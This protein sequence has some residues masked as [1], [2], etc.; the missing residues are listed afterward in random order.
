MMARNSAP[1][2]LTLV[3]TSLVGVLS[4]VSSTAHA[5]SNLR[6]DGVTVDPI[7]YSA[8][9]ATYTGHPGNHHYTG[10]NLEPG[11]QAPG[12][13]LYGADLTLASLDHA[14]LSGGHFFS[15]DFS[16]ADLHFANL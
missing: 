9:A 2:C 5:S 7:Q 15:A 13:D 12:A 11:V 14:D 10:P 16:S 3:F 8:A 6:L 4:L 1:L